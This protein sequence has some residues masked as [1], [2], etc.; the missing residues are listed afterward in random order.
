MFRFKANKECGE[1]HNIID[2]VEKKSKGIEVEKP[3]SPEL[4]VHKKVLKTF[5]KLLDNEER[6]ATAAK[7]ILDLASS[8]SQF[9]VDMSHVSYELVDFAEEM[10]LVSQSNVAIVEETTAEMLQ[11]EETIE[12]TSNTLE[13][14][15]KD[16]QEL[17]A[18]NDESLILLREV[19][20]IKENVEQVTEDLSDKFGQLVDLS[21]EV[22]KIV[23]SVQRIAEETNLLA[24]NAAIE[25]A[26]AGEYGRGFGVVAEEIR[27][28]ADDTSLNLKGMKT[29]VDDIHQATQDGRSSL[30]STLKATESM[31]QKIVLVNETVME[32][33][34]ML[35]SLIN[36]IQDINIAM[37]GVKGASNEISLAMEES[38]KGSESLSHMAEQIKEQSRS[39]SSIA[40]KLGNID[41]ELSDIITY[42]YNGLEG[43]INAL[44]N[45][46]IYEVIDKAKQSHLDWIKGLDKIVSEMRIYPIQID[47]N[48]CAFGHFYNAVSIDNPKILSD[49]N[50]IESIHLEFH[51]MG[52]KVTE[53]VRD[54]NSDLARNY[55]RDAIAL[56]EKMISLLDHIQ[57]NI[58]L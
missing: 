21:V 20:D 48:K 13:E 14:V 52:E 31:N 28:L 2:Y 33:V 42:L 3:K 46:E 9:D 11:V 23:D 39:S 58:K 44:S 4:D 27:K 54:K 7:G 50:E 53:A 49:W 38:S 8:L 25:S 18:K 17:S 16:S 26:R 19:H 56:S 51:K 5:D 37:E 43:S 34:S 10:A 47:G 12:K 1:M 45:E 40:E 32:N 41:D 22:T 15:S 55:Y 29:F 24:L 57:G 35:N 30:E 36:R 6:M